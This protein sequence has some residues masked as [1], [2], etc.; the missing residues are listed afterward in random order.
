[1]YSRLK[2]TR[3]GTSSHVHLLYIFLLFNSKEQ[4]ER[5]TIGGGG[6][7]PYISLTPLPQSAL[8]HGALKQLQ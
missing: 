1:M 7:T 4:P 3:C 6:L 2:G 5:R 8:L